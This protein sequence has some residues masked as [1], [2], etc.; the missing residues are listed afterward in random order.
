M[1]FSNSNLFTKWYP[2]GSRFTLQNSFVFCSDSQRYLWKWIVWYGEIYN[3]P[4]ISLWKVTRKWTLSTHYTGES[5]E[6]KF[7][8]Y[9]SPCISPPKSIFKFH[10][11]YADSDYF[12]GNRIV[13]N[14]AENEKFILKMLVEHLKNNFIQKFDCGCS[15]LSSTKGL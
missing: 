11:S 5:W 7:C 14:S 12:P 2:T 8:A 6:R 4:F 1:R 3:F 15:I 13:L 9:K 10:V